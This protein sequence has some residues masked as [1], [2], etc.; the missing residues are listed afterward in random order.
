[1]TKATREA[2]VNIA[3]ILH[4]AGWDRAT[5]TAPNG[6]T[7]EELV[8]QLERLAAKANQT[9]RLRVALE[10]ERVGMPRN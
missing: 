6:E 8:G 5:E 7:D 1:M 3:R 10:I 9:G 2:L 4:E